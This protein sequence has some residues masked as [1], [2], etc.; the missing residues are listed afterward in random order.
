MIIIVFFASSAMEALAQSP[1]SIP[2]QAVARDANGNILGNQ[3][4]TIRMSVLDS[5]INGPVIYQEV[6]NATTN[7]LG[8]FTLNLGQGILP[9]GSFGSINWPLNAKF[10]KVEMLLPGQVSYTLMGT[11]QLLSVP[12]ALHAKT[13][14]SIPNG[15]AIG[16][17]PYWN[18]STWTPN[19]STLF[20]NGSNIGIGTTTPI[21]RLTVDSSIMVDA[22]NGNM[23]GMAN[24]LVFGSNGSVGI[25]RSH[26]AGSSA[27]S[28][29]G[30]F[31]G[32]LR[33]MV[34]DSIGRLGIGTCCP[35]QALH[36]NG[37]SYF[38]G[39]VGIGN[40]S[41]DY[42]FENLYGYN[43]M[44]YALGLGTVPTLSY[45]LDVGTGATR[46][47]GDVRINGVLNPNNTLNIGNNTTI[48]GD[49]LV[50]TNKGIVR[51]TSSTQLRTELY[52]AN[53]LLTGLAAG[54]SLTFPI[55][56]NSFSATPTISVGDMPGT[57]TN[58]KFL[59]FT[60]K[61]ADVNSATVEVYNTGNA[62]ATYNGPFKAIIIGAH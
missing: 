5:I 24:S 54:S 40:S 55:A 49:L 9:V 47:Q 13:V 51:S 29:L 32:G 14:S 36:V 6:H 22:E 56:Y 10:L 42:A 7:S 35:Q 30:F 48:E 57:G 46:F 60:V 20:N 11:S 15:T 23:G 1:Q 37:N 17:T 41:P 62:T 39:Y 38:S 31:T 3:S 50:N 28:G 53:I 58:T 8:L 33:R 61:S 26:A 19:S 16:N 45:L 59:L 34:L 4:L 43:Y 44:Y 27:R 2:Y 18:G 25:G 21:A 52:S 12:Y